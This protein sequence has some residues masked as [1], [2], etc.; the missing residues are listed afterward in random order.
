MK[1]YVQNSGGGWPQ[2]RTTKMLDE[3]FELDIREEVIDTLAEPLA[4]ED[5]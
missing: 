2:N 1:L 5:L 3:R 4:K